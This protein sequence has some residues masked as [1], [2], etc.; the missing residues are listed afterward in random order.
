MLN[1]ATDEG[2]GFDVDTNKITIIHRNGNTIDFEL[3]PKQEVAK[4]IVN[5]LVK[6]MGIA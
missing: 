5:E 3:K 1:S 6:T 4:D 2:A